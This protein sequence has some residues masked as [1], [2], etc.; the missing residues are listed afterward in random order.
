MQQQIDTF[1]SSKSTDGQNAGEE[2]KQLEIQKTELN[3]QL[4]K[5]KKNN[6]KE[7]KLIRNDI[8]K[9]QG[10]VES[11]HLKCVEIDKE[12]RIIELKQHQKERRMNMRERLMPIS[13]TP[14]PSLSSKMGSDKSG[15]NR[16]NSNRRSVA[17]LKQLKNN[18][19][20]DPYSNAGFEER[21]TRDRT[22]VTK[23]H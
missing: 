6:E 20:D 11:L 9:L 22:F 16:F 23:R 4:Q 10:H 19:S 8:I 7:I 5:N 21:S 15:K 14:V 3:K 1:K 12:R 2:L 18:G 17:N 13:N